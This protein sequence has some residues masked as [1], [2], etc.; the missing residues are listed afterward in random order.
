MCT[1]FKLVSVNK[2]SRKIALFV[3]N[4]THTHTHIRLLI[5]IHK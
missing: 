2:D 1:L 5:K 3:Q 4:N